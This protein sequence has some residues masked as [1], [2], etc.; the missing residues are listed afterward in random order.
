VRARA[1]PQWKDTMGAT[2]V[3]ITQDNFET[4]VDREGIVVLDW[5]ASWCGPC[6]AFGP[7]YESV[8]GKHPDIVFGKVNTEDEQTLAAAFEIRSI[9]T[10]MIL[11]D[12]ILVFSQA[13]ALSEAALEDLIRQVRTLDMD[14]VRAEIAAAEKKKGDATA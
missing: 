11:R 8:A 3:Q 6:R 12:R 4:T 10:L 1:G 9:P 7:V 2:T 14:A 13:G 5:W